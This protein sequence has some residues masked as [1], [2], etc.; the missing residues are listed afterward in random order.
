MKEGRNDRNK[1][2]IKERRQKNRKNK[3]NVVE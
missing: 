2:K 3:R 1:Y